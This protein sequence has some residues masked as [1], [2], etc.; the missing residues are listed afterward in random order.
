PTATSV[1]TP[2]Q[3]ERPAA[4]PRRL[5]RLILVIIGI[6]AWFWSQSLIGARPSG[7]GVIGDGVHTLTAEWNQYLNEHSPLA[8][9][10]L[11]ASS[12]LIDALGIFLIGRSIV[13]PS[14]RPFIAL[15]ILF[16]F[17]QVCQMLCALPPP[18]GI[19][20]HDPGF[21]SLLV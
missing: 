8:N 3:G 21:P 9:G 18:E 7:H 12:A 20:W 11:I 5:L 17:R 19:I 4:K 16:V 1:D 2:R 14:F 6:A 10:L 13:G 15:L